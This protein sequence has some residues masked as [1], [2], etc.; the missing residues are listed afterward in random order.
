MA[1]G[2]LIS[3]A[4]YL[5]TSYRPDCDYVD[6]EVLER[7]IWANW[8]MAR[9]QTAIAAWIFRSPTEKSEH[10]YRCRTAGSSLGEGAFRI[11]DVSV[12]EPR[13]AYGTYS[14]CAADHL[15]RSAVEVHDTMRSLRDRANDYLKF[16]SPACLGALIL[17][18]TRGLCLRCEGL[19]FAWRVRSC[20]VAEERRSF[21]PCS[22]YSRNS[23]DSGHRPHVL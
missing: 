1:T 2:T 18:L 8:S 21:C 13:S 3:V 19:P 16:G 22:K 17:L 23:T 6:G 7:A 4:E 10:N 15:L 5:N 20:V 12:F 11:P 14:A 9:L